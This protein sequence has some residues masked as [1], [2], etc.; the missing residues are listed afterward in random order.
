MA[1][2]DDIIALARSVRDRDDEEARAVLHDALLERYKLYRKLVEIAERRFKL[3]PFN[4]VVRI[5]VDVERL[6]EVERIRA[7]GSDLRRAFR[8]E[9]IHYDSTG[10]LLEPAEIV[11]FWLWRSPKNVRRTI[12]RRRRGR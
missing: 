11:S 3:D 1:S 2:P 6:A 10:E 5:V 9:P 12:L 4:V 8:I 7:A